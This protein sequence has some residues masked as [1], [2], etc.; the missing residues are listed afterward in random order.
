MRR[1]IRVHIPTESTFVIESYDGIVQL[2]TRGFEARHLPSHPHGF[3]GMRESV[4]AMRLRMVGAIFVDLDSR[5]VVRVGRG[6]RP[7]DERG[8]RMARSEQ[9]KIVRDGSRELRRVPAAKRAPA[10]AREASSS[11]VVMDMLRGV[12]TVELPVEDVPF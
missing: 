1:K 11:S 4:V 5:T 3:V 2:C 7:R 12:V 9:R 6:Y 8:T 10:K